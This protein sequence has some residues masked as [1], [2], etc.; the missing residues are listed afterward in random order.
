V[1]WSVPASPGSVVAQGQTVLDLADC[2]NR[3]VAVELPEREFENVK[4]GA[5]ASVR[6]IGSDLWRTGYVRQ[7]LG[8]AARA[9]DRLLAAQVPEPNP[10]YITVE[11]SLPQHSTQ[12]QSSF[13]NIGRLA[14]VRFQRTTPDFLKRISG[15]F[16]SLFASFRSDEKVARQ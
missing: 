10:G 11:V 5:P 9:D 1:V 13:C 7:V 3:F 16:Q 15:F 8:S 6:L 12:G 4:P 14:D 2:D